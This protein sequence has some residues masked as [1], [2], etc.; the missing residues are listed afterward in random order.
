MQIIEQ[1]LFYRVILQSYNT[2]VIGK[3]KAIPGRVWRQEDR[4][5]YVP[6]EKKDQLYKIYDKYYLDTFIKAPA[7]VGQIPPMPELD[8]PLAFKREPYHFQAQGIARAD[9]LGNTLIGDEPGLGKTTQGIG[10]TMLN[11]AKYGNGYP[12]LII[13]PNSLKLN[14]QSEWWTVAGQR[15]LI[16]NDRIINTWPQFY[17]AG[18]A[19]VFIVNFESLK[20]FFVESMDK[21]EAKSLMVKHIKLRETAKLFNTVIIDEIHRCKEIKTQVTKITTA[22]TWKKAHVYG[23]SGTNVVNKVDD[24]IAQLYI[25]QRL[26]DLGGEKFFTARYCDTNKYLDELNYKMHTTCF[27]KRKKNEVLTELP[28]KVYQNV[29]CDITT[30]KEYNDLVADLENY[31]RQYKNKN[32]E[33]VDRALRGQ[34]M[35]TIGLCKQV[36]ARGKLVEAFEQIDETLATG[37]KIVIFCHHKDIAKAIW[38]RYPNAVTISGSDTITQRHNNVQSFQNDPAC[39]IA[40]CSIK[41]AGVGIT[42]TA[43]SEVLFIEQP[44]HSADEDQCADRCHRIGQKNSV[45][46]RKLLGKD[47]IDEVIAEL[48]A[49]KRDLSAQ[50]T[51]GERDFEAEIIDRV[52]DSLFNRKTQNA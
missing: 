35:V 8:F 40:I 19:N 23:L 4:S 46:V 44:W 14:W 11:E 45:R 36:S 29:L 20:K 43:S 16:L 1:E 10:I 17:K 2:A 21:G 25:I 9:Q 28:D 26:G 47:T 48:I 39:R 31:L 42:L 12:A 34:I 5:W 6:K 18:M 49:E 22:L 7:V 30:R 41:A 33:E 13:C 52:A 37:Q 24:L 51:G 38:D 15:A 50:A 27:F 3:I 32:D